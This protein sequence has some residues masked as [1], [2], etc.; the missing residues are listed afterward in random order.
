RRCH[1]HTG[2]VFGLKA[3]LSV[4]RGE[5]GGGHGGAPVGKKLRSR[6]VCDRRVGAF[7]LQ[8]LEQSHR[9]SRVAVVIAEQNGSL[10][11]DRTDDGDSLDRL[12]GQSTVVLEQYH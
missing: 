1:S 12:Q 9:V 10:I 4:G 11:G 6:D 5:R 8:Y 3:G 2:T 7:F